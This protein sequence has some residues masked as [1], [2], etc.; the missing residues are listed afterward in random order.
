MTYGM[1]IPVECS[2]DQWIWEAS[3]EAEQERG[4]G[5]PGCPTAGPS[6]R[7]GILSSATPA[8]RGQPVMRNHTFPLR[9]ETPKDA[10]NKTTLEKQDTWGSL[11]DFCHHHHRGPGPSTMLGRG[12]AWT[13]P[14]NPGVWQRQA[15]HLQTTHRKQAQ[16]DTIRMTWTVVS[17]RG[18]HILTAGTT[19][20]GSGS[21]LGM[22]FLPDN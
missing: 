20:Q 10:C 14:S 11:P 12:R 18:S 9:K 3:Q 16:G 6:L 17:C 8:L 13:L 7:P 15:W 22:H 2:T 5:T 4:D 1:H 21:D 19:L